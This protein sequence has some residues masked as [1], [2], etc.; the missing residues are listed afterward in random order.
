MASKETETKV[1]D[2]GKSHGK[3]K[4]Y[5]S[6]EYKAKQKYRFHVR[7]LAQQK[8]SPELK[9]ICDKSGEDYVEGKI[10]EMFKGIITREKGWIKLEPGYKVCLWGNSR[11]DWAWHIAILTVLYLFYT[12]FFVLTY[13]LY[14]WAGD[15]ILWTYFGMMIVAMSVLAFVVAKGYVDLDEDFAAEAGK[16]KEAA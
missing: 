2:K 13:Y 9:L 7:K 15:D 12:G 8:F 5:K 10:P 1:A 3:T 16:A 6:D 4:Y 14:V 11:E